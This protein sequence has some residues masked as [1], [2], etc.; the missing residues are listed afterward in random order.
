MPLIT[1]LA[2]AAFAANSLL[3]RAALTHT[4]T[5]PAT[6]TSLRLV[7]G[8]LATWACVRPRGRVPRAGSWGSAVAL[9]AYASGFSFAYVALPAGTGALLL[10]L[11]VQATMVLGGVRRGE[12]LGPRRI[13]G[14]VVALAGLVI[15]LRPGLAAPPWFA[16]GLMLCAGAAWGIYSLRGQGAADPGAATAGNFLR[17][18]PLALLL[19]LATLGHLK[20]D[21]AGCVLAALSGAVASGLGYVLWYH[22]L[23]GLGTA[24]AASVQLAV[25]ILATLA[26]GVLLGEA[27][28]LRMGLGSLAILGGIGL[29]VASRWPWGPARA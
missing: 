20:L 27:L 1:F 13:L 19:N 6:F 23:K 15:L 9:C 8:A 29:V 24:A 4:A 25:P 7:T 14:L 3:C 16:A 2:L 11:A 28:T 5:D 17:A 21:A 10:F 12:R 22:A 26:G 18:V